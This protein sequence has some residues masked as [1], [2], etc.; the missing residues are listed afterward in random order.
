MI[1]NGIVVTDQT[2]KE[3]I[4]NASTDRKTSHYNIKKII[5]ASN[6]LSNTIKNS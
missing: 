5:F 2:N 1:F 6:N 4:L 3:F